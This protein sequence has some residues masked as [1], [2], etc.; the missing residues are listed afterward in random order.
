[1]INFKSP[2]T[3]A[4]IFILVIIAGVLIGNSIW[5]KNLLSKKVKE[6]S[7]CTDKNG[8]PSTIVDGVCKEVVIL[9]PPAVEEQRVTAPDTTRIRR[10]VTFPGIVISLPAYPGVNYKYTGKDNL[11]FNYQ[12]V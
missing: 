4:I 12:K 1:M 10:N 11:F 3:I 8:N 7:A 2:L 9:N 6:G 5:L